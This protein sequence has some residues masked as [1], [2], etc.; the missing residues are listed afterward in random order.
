M[1][2]PYISFFACKLCGNP[3]VDMVWVAS[4]VAIVA[5]R[6]VYDQQ[7]HDYDYLLHVIIVEAI[8]YIYTSNGFVR[9]RSANVCAGLD[10]ATSTVALAT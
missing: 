4:R 7:Q 2:K 9:I 1:N 6:L 8:W 10:I 5:F 3:W